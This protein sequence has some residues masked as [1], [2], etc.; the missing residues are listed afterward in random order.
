MLGK[1][2]GVILLTGSQLDIPVSEI[3]VREAKQAI[4]GNGNATKK[5]LEL[6]V[7]NLLKLA[8]PI[9]P[10]HAADALGLAIIGLY[11]SR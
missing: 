1:V 8:D 5:Q 3:P 11:R 4:T 10:D 2:T 6:G 7:R 9:K